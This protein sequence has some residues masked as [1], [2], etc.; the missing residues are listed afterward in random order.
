MGSG[1][2]YTGGNYWGTVTYGNSL[3]VETQ[4]GDAMLIQ[5]SDTTAVDFST[6]VQAQED[7][8]IKVF[9]SPATDRIFIR[10]VQPVQ[11]RWLVSALGAQERVRYDPSG[12]IDVRALP[13]GLHFL[14]AVLA[15]GRVVCTPFVKE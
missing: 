4:N 15:D 14:R 7:H 9:R 12:A 3:I 11:E 13:A 6:A 8:A 10:A 1:P 2:L 5:L